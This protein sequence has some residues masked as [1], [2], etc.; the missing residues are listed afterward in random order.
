VAIGCF[1]LRKK[2][3]S[4][5]WGQGQAA[6]EAL[7]HAGAGQASAFQFRNSFSICNLHSASCP[8]HGEIIAS[9]FPA[10]WTGPQTMGALGNSVELFPFDRGNPPVAEWL[11]NVF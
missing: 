11:W 9:W 7:Y 2:I 1:L 6:P 5:A 4:L 3:L 8:T 10:E